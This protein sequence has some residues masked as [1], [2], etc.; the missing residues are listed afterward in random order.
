MMMTDA[1]RPVAVWGDDVPVADGGQG[2]DAPPQGVAER[3]ELG[4]DGVLGVVGDQGAENNDPDRHRGDPAQPVEQAPRPPARHNQ[5]RQAGQAEQ[6]HELARVQARDQEP[7]GR[8]DHHE[9]VEAAYSRV[10]VA[11][12]TAEVYHVVDHEHQPGGDADDDVD[13][14]S[15][16]RDDDERQD[17]RHDDRQLHPGVVALHEDGIA[18]RARLAWPMLCFRGNVHDLDRVRTI[19]P[20]TRKL[21]GTRASRKRPSMPG[22]LGPCHH[23]HC[24]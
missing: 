16:P 15:G 1:Q 23:Y 11:V 20:G 8:S 9:Q 7:R 24:G 4:I 5:A 18:V 2:D 21:G 17:G 22:R 14:A 3:G 12:Q 6:D 13:Q 10:P 19:R